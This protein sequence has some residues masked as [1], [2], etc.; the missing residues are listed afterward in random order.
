[1]AVAATAAREAH[2][3][4][5]HP[6]VIGLPARRQL[7]DMFVYWEI[8]ASHLQ[9]QL[10]FHINQAIFREDFVLVC[11]ATVDSGAAFFYR[12]FEFCRRFMPIRIGRN[13]RTLGRNAQAIEQI[14]KSFLRLPAC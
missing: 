11:A 14:G 8:D 7:S 5:K 12:W 4:L 13:R 1:L 3:G 2:V 9:V 6:P 10:R